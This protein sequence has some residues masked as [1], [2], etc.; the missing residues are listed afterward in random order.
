M[1]TILITLIALSVSLLTACS[2]CCH[3]ENKEVKKAPR[4]VAVQTYTFHKF[5]LEETIEMLKK[6]NVRVLE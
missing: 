2:S 4:K 5:T 1:K 3:K 6:T